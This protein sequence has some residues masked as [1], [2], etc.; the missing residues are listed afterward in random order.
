MIAHL[1]LFK[2]KPGVSRADAR[3]QA[4]TAGMDALPR[5]ISLIRTWEHG[6]NQTQDALAY[7]YGLRA[8]F[9]N[10][11]DLHAYFDHSQHLA[12]L[13]QW[14]AISDLVFCDYMI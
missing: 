4:V 6:P 9:D 7:D 3:V 1:V 14:E 5:Q 13:R 2:L 10:E 8:L 11:G 12:V